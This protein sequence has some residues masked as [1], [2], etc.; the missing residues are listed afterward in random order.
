MDENVFYRL[1]EMMEGV[2]E[3]WDCVVCVIGYAGARR[4]DVET[5]TRVLGGKF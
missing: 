4:R 1:L 3:M 2:K 5:M